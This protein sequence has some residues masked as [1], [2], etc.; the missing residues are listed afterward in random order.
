MEQKKGEG[1][2]PYCILEGDIN[3]NSHK[4]KLTNKPLTFGRV[5][6]CIEN[7]YKKLQ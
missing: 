3:L 5:Q 1:A 2:E 7:L 6:K 4:E